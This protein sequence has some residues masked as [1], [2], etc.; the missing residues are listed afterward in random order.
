MDVVIPLAFPDYLIAIET[1][2]S[3]VA[4]PDLLPFI[5]ILPERIVIKEQKAKLPYLG[6]AGVLFFDGESGRTKYYEYG[7]YDKAAKGL[8][9]RVSIPDTK[10]GDTTTLASVL[11]AI[12]QRSGQGGAITGAYIELPDGA[13]E[14][15]LAFAQRREKENHNPRRKA[16]DI[17]SYSCL[18]F[19]VAVCEAGGASLPPIVDPR[20]TGHLAMIRLWHRDLNFQPSNAL[21]IDA[22]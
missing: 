18:H 15:M 16:Y 10:P 21:A 14:K 17:T 22:S 4:V 12:S 13:F 1:R 6:H 8:V 7:R 9:R 20:P 3:V 5:D 19:A 2:Q 11:N